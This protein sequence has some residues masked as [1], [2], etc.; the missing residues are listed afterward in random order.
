MREARNRSSPDTGPV[1]RGRRMVLKALP[2]SCKE[3]G[4]H[5]ERGVGPAGLRQGQP[6]QQEASNQQTCSKAFLTRACKYA[7]QAYSLTS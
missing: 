7:K 5:V 1:I 2:S 4:G 3:A 6:Q